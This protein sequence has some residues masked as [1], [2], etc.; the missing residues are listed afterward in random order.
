MHKD[1]VSLR[2]KDGMYPGN[3]L[4]LQFWLLT[5][6]KWWSLLYWHGSTCILHM[7]TRDWNEEISSRYLHLDH[8]QL[9][10]VY[11]IYMYIY[12]SD[13]TWTSLCPKSLATRLFVQELVAADIRENIKATHHWPFVSGIHR[14]PMDSPHKGRI[15]RK[16]RP[17]R[18][19]IMH[20]IGGYVG[21]NSWC[22]HIWHL[23]PVSI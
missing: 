2:P 18:D 20:F 19:V 13:V 17:W 3:N 6:F 15:M 8:L 22:I 23:C 10:N 12:H 9:S 7:W 14:W 16:V 1:D 21:R 11:I 4:T 5:P